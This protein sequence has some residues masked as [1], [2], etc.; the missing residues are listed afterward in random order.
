MTEGARALR[1]QLVIGFMCVALVVY[2]VM[3]GRIAMAFITSGSAA[4]IG[5]GLALMILPLIGIWA[6]ISTLKAGLADTPRA[7]AGSLLPGITT[8]FVGWNAPATT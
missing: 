5:L 4:A 6:M 1:I 7:A 8:S 2:F 3:L